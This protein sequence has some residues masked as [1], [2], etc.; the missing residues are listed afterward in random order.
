MSKSLQFKRDSKWETKENP[1]VVVSI[2][3]TSDTR[4]Y[5][6][7]VPFKSCAYCNKAPFMLHHQSFDVFEKN[8]NP[9]N[10]NLPSS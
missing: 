5:F 6:R 2:Q 8:F 9:H 7:C 10:S 3:D 1:E 4:I